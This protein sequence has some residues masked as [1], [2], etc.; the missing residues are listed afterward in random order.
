MAITYVRIRTGYTRTRDLQLQSPCGV[1]CRAKKKSHKNSLP[2]A[3]CLA[4]ACKSQIEVRLDC[5]Q[6]LLGTY[7]LSSPGKTSKLATKYW[8]SDQCEGL[9]LDFNLLKR[10]ALCV[11]DVELKYL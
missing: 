3:S 11:V 8:R 6:L 1:A 9:D 2:V 5:S 7:H 10:S 4:L